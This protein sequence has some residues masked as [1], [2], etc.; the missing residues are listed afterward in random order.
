MWLRDFGTNCVFDAEISKYLLSYNTQAV[1]HNMH[2]KFESTAVFH[3]S[4]WQTHLKKLIKLARGLNRHEKHNVQKTLPCCHFAFFTKR[5]LMC[6]RAQITPTQN[7]Q[8]GTPPTGRPRWQRLAWRK[9]TRANHAKD[10]HHATAPCPAH[11]FQGPSN[12]YGEQGQRG[13][14]GSRLP[15]TKLRAEKDAQC[16][17]FAGPIAGPPST[18]QK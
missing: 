18:N 17:E 9:G 3:V 15:G 10:Y 7:F 2:K 4:F 6:S 1:F 12:R 11:Q 14:K 5:S 8:D 16:W 13:L